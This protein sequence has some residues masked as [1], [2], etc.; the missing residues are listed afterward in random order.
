VDLNAP[1]GNDLFRGAVFHL[2]M[3]GK[4][5]Y[6]HVSPDTKFL[7]DL[8]HH[9]YG[10]MELIGDAVDDKALYRKIKSDF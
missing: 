1:E 8:L 6:T 2:P 3:L 5:Y 10:G 4:P 7:M 9:T